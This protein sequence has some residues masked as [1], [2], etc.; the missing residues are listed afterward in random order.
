MLL[1]ALA[2][3]ALKREVGGPCV[4]YRYGAQ[5]AASDTTNQSEARHRKRNLSSSLN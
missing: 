5:R 1:I 2:C 3:D 4:A